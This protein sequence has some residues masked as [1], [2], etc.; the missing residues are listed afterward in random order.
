MAGCGG[1][2]KEL[3]RRLGLESVVGHVMAD[4]VHI[5][6]VI[7]SKYSVANTVG[8]RKGKASIMI[9]QKVLCL[10]ILCEYRWAGKGLLDRS[11]SSR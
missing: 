4:H 10:R 11:Y 1:I 3:Y 5:C 7:P 9:H 6:L 2:C 8:K